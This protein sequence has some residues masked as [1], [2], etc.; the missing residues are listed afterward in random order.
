[1]AA[2][3][4][5]ADFVLSKTG[6]VRSVASGGRVWQGHVD[7]DPGAVPPPGAS[8]HHLAFDFESDDYFR[9]DNR[10]HFAVGLRGDARSD[11]NGDGAPDLRGGGVVLG[12][13]TEYPRHGDCGPTKRPSTIAIESFWAGGNCIHPLSEGP[14]LRNGTRY[15]VAVSYRVAAGATPARRI[16]YTLSQRTAGGWTRIA[17][18]SV[19]DRINPS[20]PDLGG[21]FLVEVFSTHDWTFRVYNL[22][23]WW[24]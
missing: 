7:S 18:R 14:E 15:R 10:G 5:G 24:S 16:T 3:T 9:R 4:P 13:V 1:V 22:R 21:W 2:G 23:Q 20:P 8:T 19:D 6:N 12:N 11:A 17:T